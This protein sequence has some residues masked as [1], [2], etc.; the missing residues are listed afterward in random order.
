MQGDVMK[1]K[2]ITVVH[3]GVSPAP[4]DGKDVH[5]AGVLGQPPCRTEGHRP[6]G[7]LFSQ[8]PGMGHW[9]KP[10]KWGPLSLASVYH[11]S[12]STFLLQEHTYVLKHGSE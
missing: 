2:D 9:A 8:H 7:A 10:S 3:T 4:A 6:S 5:P 11:L 1:S 12:E